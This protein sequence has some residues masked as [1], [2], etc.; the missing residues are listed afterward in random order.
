MHFLLYWL[1]SQH[2]TEGKY[3]TKS[4][5]ARCDSYD[6]ARSL[7]MCSAFPVADPY[8]TNNG[9]EDLL[10]MM[11]QRRRCA[12]AIPVDDG[13]QFGRDV[14]ARTHGPTRN[15]RGER[16]PDDGG[17]IVVVVRI[18]FPPARGR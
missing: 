8:R 13:V 5:S 10:A 16:A 12:F 17:G 3:P 9:V 2:I 14:P 6:D 7:A 11:R 4:G 18:T 15:R 1:S